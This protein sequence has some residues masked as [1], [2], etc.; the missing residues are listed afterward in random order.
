MGSQAALPH[1]PRSKRAERKIPAMLLVGW[2]VNGPGP[3]DTRINV[4]VVPQ[5]GK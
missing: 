4:I 2:L 1:I 5:R 3:R